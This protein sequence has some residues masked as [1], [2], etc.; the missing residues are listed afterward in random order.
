MLRL[1]RPVVEP[2]RVLRVSFY[3]EASAD[4]PAAPKSSAR[5]DLAV[6]V[7][8]PVSIFLRVLT[9]FFLSAPGRREWG[10][11]L[12]CGRLS[13]GLFRNTLMR[14]QLLLLMLVAAAFVSA[15][16][17]Q[18]QGR[19]LKGSES[20]PSS[21]TSTLIV[22]AASSPTT[23]VRLTHSADLIVDAQVIS[24]SSRQIAPSLPNLETDVLVGVSEVF[25][26]DPSIRELV[27]TQSGGVLGQYR[28]IS[29]QY[30]LMQPGERYFL[31]LVKDTRTELPQIENFPRY[32]I[33][34][35][36]S[37]MFRID[38]NGNVRV[39]PATA[40]SLK[41]QVDGLPSTLVAALVKTSMNPPAAPP[42]PPRLP[43]P[44]VK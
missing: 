10:R 15:Q 31:F 6:V 42:P 24:V 5:Y 23:L 29:A 39:A 20:L 12:T 2:L 27:V 1:K 21:G 14:L 26:G 40:E 18:Q 11:L 30:S 32:G 17:Q 34:G 8:R 3:G 4:C 33:R 41:R 25:K 36:W 37:G 19:P 38:A 16:A 13:I 28:E 43:V 35:V 44:S 9:G 22:D 7:S